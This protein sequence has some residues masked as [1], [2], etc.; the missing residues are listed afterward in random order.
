MKKIIFGGTGLLGSAIKEEFHG[1]KS[2]SSKDIDLTDQEVTKNWFKKN[3]K[4][5]EESIVFICAGKVSGIGGQKNYEMLIKNLKIGI[6]L[7]E[8]LKKYQKKGYSIYFSSSCVYPEKLNN[9]YEDDLFKGKFEKTNEGYA[10]AKATCQTLS[11]FSNIDLGKRQF[12]N[13]IPSNIWGENDNWDLKTGHVLTSI[14]RKIYN[15]K[16]SNK[17]EVFLWG[18]PK[19]KREF[20][21]SNDVALA[22]KLI[23]KS[24]TKNNTFNVGN[25]K[26][27]TIIWLAKEIAKKLDYKGKILFSG[28]KV[29]QKQKL[30]NINLISSLGWKPVYDY[31]DM[32]NFVS[33]KVVSI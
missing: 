32:V 29:G 8:N 26:D 25:G 27:F 14:T 22:V 2:L 33:K 11:N 30:M 31:N 12:L 21:K 13:I 3:K 19:T 17:N 16:K 15:A 23:L 10:I 7:F 9:Y 4:L 28:E 24:K 1:V 5:V 6:N 18:S 20:I